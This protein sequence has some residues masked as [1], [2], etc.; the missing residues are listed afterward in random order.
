MRRLIL[1]A[2]ALAFVSSTAFAQ[3]PDKAGGT[4]APAAQSGD[5]TSKDATKEKMASKKKAKKPAKKSSDDAT[6]Q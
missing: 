4:A 1:A 3:T 5:T 6:K 2:T